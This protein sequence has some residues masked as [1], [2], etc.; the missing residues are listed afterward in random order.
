[1]GQNRI[2]KVYS[3]PTEVFVNGHKIGILELNGDNHEILIPKNILAS[4][5]ELVIKTGRN[6]FQTEYIDYDD[7]E[8]GNIRIEVKEKSFYARH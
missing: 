1:M 4:S 7:I 3:S 6:L 8:L 5:N 2:A